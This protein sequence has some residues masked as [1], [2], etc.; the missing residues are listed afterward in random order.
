MTSKVQLDR[1]VIYGIFKHNLEKD[2]LDLSD[3]KLGVRFI[4]FLNY[5]TILTGQQE[6]LFG[7]ENGLRGGM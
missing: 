7:V 3:F 6:M 2:R 4:L 5:L 1:D